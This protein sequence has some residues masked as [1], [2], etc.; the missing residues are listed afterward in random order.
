[1]WVI[2]FFPPYHQDLSWQL[3]SMLFCAGVSQKHQTPTSKDLIQIHSAATEANSLWCTSGEPSLWR[4]ASDCQLKAIHSTTKKE[5]KCADL[6]ALSKIDMALWRNADFD[7]SLEFYSILVSPLLAPS[8]QNTVK[9]AKSK[10]KE[11]SKCWK[12]TGRS[13]TRDLVSEWSTHCL[14]RF[15]SSKCGEIWWGYDNIVHP[16]WGVNVG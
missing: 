14:N 16:F 13:G 15:I 6:S 12:T 3:E 5:K 9:V 2:I 8:P 4:Q 10:N 1:M 11:I 7:S